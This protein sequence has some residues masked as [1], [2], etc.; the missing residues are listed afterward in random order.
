MS[1]GMWCWAQERPVRAIINVTVVPSRSQN[2][3]EGKK[4]WPSDYKKLGVDIDT[5]NLPIHQSQTGQHNF[6][7]V[8]DQKDLAMLEDRPAPE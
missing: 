2:P 3:Q 8:K 5:L 1:T 7:F 6:I 4:N